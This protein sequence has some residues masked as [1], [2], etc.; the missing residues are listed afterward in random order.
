MPF[1]VATIAVDPFGDLTIS[2]IT[3]VNN[4]GGNFD[5]RDQN[6]V[7]YWSPTFAGVQV[8]LAGTSNEGKT[9]TTNPRDYG[10]SVQWTRGP[11]YAFYAYEEHR[12]PAAG[13]T[14]EDGN[15]VGGSVGFGPV[16]LGGLYEEFKKTGATKKKSWMG[17]VVYTIGNNQL[18]GQYQHAEDGGASG[19]RFQPECD[20]GSFGYQ[21]N[22]TRRTF[23][24]GQYTKVWNSGS[25]SCNFGANRLAIANGQDPQ[26]I[27]VGL[28]HIF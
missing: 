14:K 19:A 5:R 4:D 11:F 26:G 10:A 21:Y 20:S 23:F 1:K 12:D 28:R 3:G 22:F 24:L 8:R 16:K 2:G 6:V 25:A 9:A 27:S 17:N 15:A 18:I 7:Q 13:I